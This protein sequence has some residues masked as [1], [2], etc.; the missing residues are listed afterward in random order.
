M[1]AYAAAC[2]LLNEYS[3]NAF[4]ILKILTIASIPHSFCI[5]YIAIKR[6]EGNIK[7]ILYTYI[8]LVA[9]TIIAG[10]LFMQSL[11]LIGV[12]VGWLLGNIVTCGIIGVQSVKH[13]F[14]N[15]KNDCFAY[16]SR[17]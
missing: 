2:D 3:E 12:G 6:V 14:K 1:K 9:I 7:S 15:I 16:L 4:M 13:N 8:I 17:Q 5:L 11:G 10:Y